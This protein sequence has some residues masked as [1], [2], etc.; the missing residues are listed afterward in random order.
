MWK[1]FGSNSKQNNI[2]YFFNPKTKNVI[3]T[4]QNETKLIVL[5]ICCFNKARFKFSICYQKLFKRFSFCHK[6]KGFLKVRYWKWIFESIHSFKLDECFKSTYFWHNNTQTRFVRAEKL[7]INNKILI[8]FPICATD[9]E[10]LTSALCF[11]TYR[12]TTHL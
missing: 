4:D 6:L 11:D 1:A 2:R 3:F 10:T 9:I 5:W 7:F 12:K 8:S